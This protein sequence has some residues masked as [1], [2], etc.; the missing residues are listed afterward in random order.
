MDDQKTGSKPKLTEIRNTAR[1]LIASGF[2]PLP[3][4][5][6]QK[7]P[8]LEGW[9]HAAITVEQVDSL[10]VDDCNIG[11]RLDRVTDID[12][13][14]PQAIILAPYFLKATPAQWGRAT[15]RHS[16]WVYDVDG[17]RSEKFLDPQDEKML[18]EI[19]HGNGYQSM[20][21]PSVHPNGE[22]LHW[23]SHSPLKPEK[24][25]YSEL[26]RAVSRIA[27]GV[28]LSRYLKPGIRQFTWLYLSGAMKRAE[29]KLDEALHFVRIISNL[30]GDD[31]IPNRL[32][33][34]EHSY[35][36]EETAGLKKLEDYLPKP[37]IRNLAKWLDLRRAKFDPLDLS[38]DANA[39]FL[40]AK[41]GEDLRYLPNEGKGGLWT[42]WN[43][44]IWQRD[45]M[46]YVIHQS[47][48]SLKIKADELTVA[49]R[50]GKFIEK[51]RRELLNMPGINGALDRLSNYPEIATPSS[52]FDV[53][54]WLIGLQNGIYDL[55]LDRLVTGTREHLVSRQMQAA[56]E[57]LAQCPRWLACLER[58][59]PNPDV[60]S[61]L[62]RLAGSCLL[63]MQTEHGFVFN[64]GKGANFKTAYAEILRRIMGSDYATTPNEELF[65]SGNQE[66]PRNYIADIHGMRLLTT[67][68]KNEGS[69]WNIEFIKRL[70]G[71]QELVGKRLYC[72]AFS[73]VPTARIIVAAN[74][75]PR[76]NELDEALRRRFLLT[77]W[78][79][80]I[81]EQVE[82]MNL[83]SSTEKNSAIILDHLRRGPRMP[84]E[85]LMS[86]LLEERDGILRWMIDGFRDFVNRGLRLDPPASIRKATDDYFEDEDIA[87]RF[88]KDWCEIVPVPDS[89]AYDKLARWL[90]ANGSSSAYIHKAFTSWSQF[91]KPWGLRRITQRL[92][93]VDGV[94]LQR[95]FG[96]R[97]FMNLRLTDAALT[98]MDEERA[99]PQSD[100]DEQENIPF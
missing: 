59:Q 5:D 22:P 69:E 53:N 70:L 79:I 87:G 25:T 62:Q 4:P 16:H 85:Q 72:E 55:Q 44:V 26:H 54:P 80:K 74:N 8:L 13:D 6:G 17:S 73:F 76:L 34:V 31:K 20:I 89:L 28:L 51:V 75:K 82:G 24:W 56:Y 99:A 36:T 96:N 100:A 15:A 27:A 7:R 42:F 41:H 93:K 91:G 88:V 9:Q 66:V 38:D 46:G 83:L 47:G 49:S 60:R 67:N 19:R 12:L 40:F 71:G 65:F 50:D 21:P 43:D 98:Q 77:T 84:F 78:D 81:P 58:A 92:S 32:Q 61:F 52:R 37:V 86:L 64:Y 11:W 63:G 14:T 1:L 90:K 3:L 33:A 35:Q 57:P 68:E 94:V 95:G 10:F 39:Q 30:I 18:V 45:R 29:W 48:N 97:T 23:E 2:A